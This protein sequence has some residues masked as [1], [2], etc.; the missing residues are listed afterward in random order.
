MSTLSDV[1]SH[2]QAELVEMTR[3][4]DD[5][6]LAIAESAMSLSDEQRLLDLSVRNGLTNAE[7]EEIETLRAR[8]GR[9]T[10]RR[11]NALGLLSARG[12]K[13]HPAATFK[14]A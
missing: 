7:R 5:A 2:M 14:P 3:L 13:K 1:P 6:L 8:Y 11:A 10:L 9:L 4:D 12:C